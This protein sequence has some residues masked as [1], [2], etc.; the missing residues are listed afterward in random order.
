VECAKRAIELLGPFKHRLQDEAD[1]LGPWEACGGRLALSEQLAFER[2]Y[3]LAKNFR[4]QSHLEQGAPRPKAVIDQLTKLETMSGELARFLESLDD[5]TLHQLQTHGT[6]ISVAPEVIE[7]SPLEAA[8]IEALPKP[9]LWNKEETEAL[10][11]VLL[12]QLSQYSGFSRGVFVK[13]KGIEDIDAPDKGGN[14]NLYKDIYGSARWF[15]AH[16]GWH[17]Y[18]LFKPGQ[19]TGTEGGPFHLFLMH[20]FEYA[21]GEDPETHSKLIS[22]VKRS[23]KANRTYANI[24]ARRDALSDEM[25]AFR[26]TL[27]KYTPEEERRIA[28]ISREM[29]EVERERFEAWP[30]LYPYSYRGSSQ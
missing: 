8:V 6:G 9:S 13:S 3:M 24:I 15:L 22:H 23:S 28:E 10:L 26:R 4:K 1:R 19:A 25:R 16:D 29:L 18:E 27:C 11:V 20:T 30:A 2:V 14:H 5:M 17:N 12:K 7:T 21:T